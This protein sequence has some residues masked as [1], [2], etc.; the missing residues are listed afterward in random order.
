MYGPWVDG[1]KEIQTGVTTRDNAYYLVKYD[2]FVRIVRDSDGAG[3][4]YEGNLDAFKPEL[5]NTYVDAGKNY[6]LAETAPGV[7]PQRAVVEVGSLK[8]DV[9]S[10]RPVQYAL[11]KSNNRE[12]FCLDVPRADKANGVQLHAWDCLGIDNQQFYAENEQIKIKHSGKCLDVAS[13]SKDNGGIV[14]QWDCHGG[15]NQKWIYDKGQFKPKH[16]PGKCLDIV[17]GGKQ[18]GS[19]MQIWDCHGGN[20]QKW[21]PE[22]VQ[23][24]IVDSCINECTT[25]LTSKNKKYSAQMSPENGN[26]IVLDNTTGK[27]VW[28]SNSANRGKAPYKWFM[29]ADGNL[30]IY[31]ANNNPIWANGSAGKGKP[32]YKL[33]MQDDYN[34][35]VYGATGSIWASR[36]N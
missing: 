9:A 24:E 21:T 36:E 31:D 5:W 22:Q 29:Q 19:L 2:K 30:V 27:M 6:L 35:V 28:Q 32:P 23:A 10:P 4:Y 13:A 34:L 18:N 26:L 12:N 3:R 8:A 16:A 1:F 20:N 7:A 15:D 14:Q 25:F 11:I 33:V 17:A